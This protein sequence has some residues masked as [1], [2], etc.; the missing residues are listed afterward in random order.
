VVVTTLVYNSLINSSNDT[1]TGTAGTGIDDAKDFEIAV[2]ITP[3]PVPATAWLF[4]SG[5]LGLIGVARR[6][7]A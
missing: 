2:G 6:K 3:V 1:I 7:K 4:C 5:L